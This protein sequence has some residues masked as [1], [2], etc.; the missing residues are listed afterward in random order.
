MMTIALD[1][2]GGDKAPALVVYGAKIALKKIPDLRLIFFGNEV[3]LNH[4]IK[5]AK[6][7]VLYGNRIE[8]CHTADVVTNHM[9]PSVALRKGRKSSMAL[10]IN[11]V[12]E[13]KADA[14]VSAGNT[15]ALMALSLFTL[16]MLPGI[17]R[18]AIATVI[19]SY[20]K[21]CLMLDLGANA[22]CSTRN[23][24][25][26]ANM[27]H[28]YAQSI[29]GKINPTIG[30]L[31]IGE[32]SGKGNKLIQDAHNILKH[33]NLGLNYYG[34]VE[35]ND[36]SHGVVDV[37]ITDG[38]TGNIALKTLEGTLRTAKNIIMQE[39]KKSL[40]AKLGLFI[41]QGA[42]KKVF[43]RVDPRR[44]NGAWLLGVNGVCVKSHGGTDA[45]GFYNAIK[46]AYHTTQKEF[47]PKMKHYLEEHQTDFWL[48]E[49]N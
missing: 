48:E 41:A 30:L 24:T 29:M 34:F 10:A 47:L 2:M 7:D 43:K 26:F 25:E 23:L 13:G 11:A 36:I 49:E 9:K 21:D 12:K 44:Y 16:R 27:G 37:I 5:E 3:Q 35:G 4:L 46:H 1:A 8:I 40:L 18:P 6:L 14:V 31:N 32:E 20:K 17:D 39:V 33:N 22:E 38:F 28:V 15:G 42:L 45:F 19:A